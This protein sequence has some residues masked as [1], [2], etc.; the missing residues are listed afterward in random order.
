MN[1]YYCVKHSINGKKLT[2]GIN[3]TSENK[4]K[5]WSDEYKKGLFEK[6]PKLTIEQQEN[7][8]V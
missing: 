6:S 2:V 3:F 4:A 7:R 8:I 1:N 5:I